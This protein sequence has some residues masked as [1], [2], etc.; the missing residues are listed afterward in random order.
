M[1]V[2]RE[3]PPFSTISGT[4]V[5]LSD[6]ETIAIYRWDGLSWVAHFR[7]GCGELHDAA[8]W[9]KAYAGLLRSCRVGRIAALETVEVLT[10]ELISKIARLHRR[11][12]ADEA[13]RAQVW[14]NAVEPLRRAWAQLAATLHAGGASVSRRA[15]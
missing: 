5:R 9:F 12:D 3:Q 7:D 14:A 4:S 15:G 13:A 6:R 2:Q 8:T 1:N 11:R 10:P